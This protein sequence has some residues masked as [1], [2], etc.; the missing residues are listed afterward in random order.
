MAGVLLPFLASKLGRYVA[1][2]LAVLGL[3]GSV[4]MKGRADCGAKHK[5]AAARIEQEWRE[6]VTAAERIAYQNGLSA[7]LV[8]AENEET[9]HDVENTAASEAGSD[10][11]CLSA[12]VVDRVRALQ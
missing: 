8:E 12:D 1:G 3:L 5:R 6:K 11:L 4:Y 2:A 10:D 9:I 7:A